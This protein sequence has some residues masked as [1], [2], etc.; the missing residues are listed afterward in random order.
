MATTYAKLVVPLLVDQD[1]IAETFNAARLEE[2]VGFFRPDVLPGLSIDEAIERVEDDV[3]E[4]VPGPSCLVGQR[5]PSE[6]EQVL[7]EQYERLTSFEI[8]GGYAG[9]WAAPG[10]LVA[11]YFSRERNDLVVAVDADTRAVCQ[12]N[13]HLSQMRQAWNDAWRPSAN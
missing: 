11:G 3:L 9:A 8:N 2:P 7:S 1:I 10:L 6:Y 4:L 12:I 5:L 13:A